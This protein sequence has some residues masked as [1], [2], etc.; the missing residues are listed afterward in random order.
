MGEKR[1]QFFYCRGP[2]CW[3]AF[4]ILLAVAYPDM[5]A[6]IRVYQGL[7]EIMWGR[8]IWAAFVVLLGGI[9]PFCLWGIRIKVNESGIGV[10]KLFKSSLPFVKWNGLKEV[11]EGKM[12]MNRWL[13]LKSDG[14][15]AN[16]GMLEMGKKQ[17]D[18]LCG[19]VEEFLQ[20]AHSDMLDESG[21]LAP[22]DS[23]KVMR[24]RL[25][26]VLPLA[27]L[28][29][30]G[31]QNF[32]S[33][34][35]M[36][37][38]DNKEIGMILY[39]GIRHERDVGKAR[40]YLDAPDFDFLEKMLRDPE[41]TISRGDWDPDIDTDH[42]IGCLKAGGF[43]A[44]LPGTAEEWLEAGSNSRSRAVMLERLKK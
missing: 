36:P 30:V 3:G 40:G 38:P 35:R 7:G 22:P 23:K 17:Y 4:L 43:L 1:E 31:I 32:R 42:A 44:H 18:L 27:V 25:L 39:C 13:V 33:F 41:G 14:G 5:A 24:R 37:I 11:R 20:E 10:E 16:I 21:K 9:Y 8:L 28:F 12:G 6:V 2:L 26:W 15:K 34:I 29:S 19:L